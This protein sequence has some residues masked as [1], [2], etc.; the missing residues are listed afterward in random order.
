MSRLPLEMGGSYEWNLSII[1]GDFLIHGDLSMCLARCYKALDA[2][3]TL[4]ILLC[5]TL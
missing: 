1:N 5:I 3:A 2:S 4:E